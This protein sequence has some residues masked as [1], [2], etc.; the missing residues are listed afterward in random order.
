MNRLQAYRAAAATALMMSL[1]AALVNVQPTRAQPQACLHGVNE[2]P[3]QR[4]RRQQALRF[5]REI[6][7]AEAAASRTAGTYQPL[8][9]LQ[10]SVPPGDFTVDLVTNGTG[11]VFSVKDTED[12]CRFSFFSDQ[13]GLIYV[14]Q[15][16]Q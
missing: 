1:G 4:A 3:A 9:A 11:Y 7:T 6:N 5:T 13:V 14:G 12:A 2:T 16:L 8:T 10:L 15:P